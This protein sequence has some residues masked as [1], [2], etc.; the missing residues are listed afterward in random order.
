[1]LSAAPAEKDADPKFFH[2]LPVWTQREFRVNRRD[3]TDL[4]ES[5]FW[6]FQRMQP[7]TSAAVR[8]TFRVPSVLPTI[9]RESFRRRQPPPF[10]GSGHSR[11]AAPAHTRHRRQRRFPDHCRCRR[12]ARPSET[13]LPASRRARLVPA[14]LHP[15][16]HPS[17]C[18]CR[19][20]GVGQSELRG[21]EV[22]VGKNSGDGTHAL[23]LQGSALSL[24]LRRIA[25]NAK[26]GRPDFE[27]GGAL[28]QV[29]GDESPVTGFSFQTL[30]GPVLPP[31]RRCDCARQ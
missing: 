18:L 14:A 2:D 15:Y 11:C 26:M 31:D 4:W 7:V 13:A 19:R 9:V 16:S 21:I 10:P 23:K 20:K 29:L 3:G 12:L 6:R 27:P 17:E 30:K 24:F 8:Q 28:A 22:A 25:D 1:V 5:W